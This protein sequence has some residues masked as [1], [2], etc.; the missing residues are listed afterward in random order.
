[1]RGRKTGGRTKGAKNK[2]TL[3]LEEA[4]KAALAA[5]PDDITSLALMQ[6]VYRNRSFDLPTRIAAATK[7]LPYEHP[8]LSSVEYLPGGENMMDQRIKQ[9]RGNITGRLARLRSS[10][11]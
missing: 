8:T 9:A 7:A 11:G 10:E 4:A 2:R 5:L 1:M 3:A 6:A